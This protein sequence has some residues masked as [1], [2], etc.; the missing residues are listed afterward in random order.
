MANEMNAKLQEFL[1]DNPQ[2][3]GKF[4]GWTRKDGLGITRIDD[5]WYE[6]ERYLVELDDLIEILNTGGFVPPIGV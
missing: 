5:R 1:A 4:V 3:L 6:C 2:F